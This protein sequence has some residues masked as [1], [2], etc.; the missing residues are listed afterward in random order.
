MPLVH[1]SCRDVATVLGRSAAVLAC[2]LALTSCTSGGSEAKAANPCE[3]RADAQ[4]GAL[5]RGI[6]SVESFE[7]KASKSTSELTDKMRFVLRNMKP[8]KDSA[9][10][11]ACTYGSTDGQ[12]DARAVF[13]FGW[14]PRE[15]VA[16]PTRPGDSAYD[17]NG[18]RATA[19]TTASA[20][21]VQCDLPGDLAAESRRV[22]LSADAYFSFTPSAPAADQAAK[23]RRATLTY[24]M[25]RRVTEALGCENKP[26]A[27]AP[28]VKP[29]PGP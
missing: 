6:L 3:I 22:W 21:L 1:T 24:L 7:T 28:V 26:L 2:V 13:S 4:E 23:D 19:S 15:A 20:L 12:R 25:T 11:A 9:S 17:A 8:G 5:V 27:Q 10:N 29:A 14:S 18:S 16:E